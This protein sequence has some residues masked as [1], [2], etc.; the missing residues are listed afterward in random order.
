MT[1]PTSTSHAPLDYAPAARRRGLRRALRLWPVGLL[2]VVGG[3]G[4]AYGPG[5]WRH[6]KL[7]RLQAACMT[8]QMPQDRPVYDEEPAAAAALTAAWPGEYQIAPGGHGDGVA[9]QT[10][11]RWAAFAV[12]AG[13]PA[14]WGAA[15]GKVGA[16][17]LFCHERRTP[18]GRRRLVVVEGRAW[19]FTVIEPGTWY[20]RRPRVIRRGWAWADN[21]IY[22][23]LG[24]TGRGVLL[25]P[26]R[27]G[28]GTPDPVDRSRFSVPFV[29]TGVP[30]TL[31]FRLNDDDTVTVRVVDPH[32]FAARAAASKAA[33]ER[34]A[35][36]PAVPEGGPVRR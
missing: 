4:V 28:G 23:A 7:M 34:A 24:V 26:I 13:A 31:E 33:R 10:D 17:V 2:V 18:P 1:D 12:E 22:A 16:A 27:V 8:A 15:G 21:A 11:P 3:L 6:V 25:E 36:R 19:A 20:G 9:A 35:I 5:A 32:G 14:S 29:L 30:G